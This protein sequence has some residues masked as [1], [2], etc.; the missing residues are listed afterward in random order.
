MLDEEEWRRL[1]ERLKNQ[2]WDQGCLLQWRADLFLGSR[3]NPITPEAKKATQGDGA[4]ALAFEVK[5]PD[6]RMVIVSQ[7][8]DIVSRVEPLVEAI[9]LDTWPKEKDL[10]QLNSARF[11]VLDRDERLVADATRRLSFEKTLLPD[12]QA[13]QLCEN[14]DALGS[15]RAWCARRYSRVAFSDDFVAT[16]GSALED[17]LRK[18]SKETPDARDALHTWRVRLTQEGDAPIQVALLAVYDEQHKGATQVKPFVEAVLRQ[19]Q[20]AL[21][22]Y[23]KK[24]KELLKKQGVEGE[25]LK[26]Q[27]AAAVPVTMSQVS[28]RDLRTYPALNLEHMTYDGTHAIGVEPHEEAV[29]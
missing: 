19:A 23:E 15:F 12:A 22:T 21:P 25:L 28:L 17:A 24:A 7:R 18:Q 10:P 26:H 16:V 27:I 4:F 5:K 20:E 9:P 11:Y 3:D 8:C 2:G 1:I 14:D 13:K 29:A 6:Q